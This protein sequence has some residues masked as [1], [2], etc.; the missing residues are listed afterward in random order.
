VPAAAV[1]K[2]EGFCFV[3]ILEFDDRARATGQGGKRAFTACSF[4]IKSRGN[5]FFFFN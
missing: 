1:S 4:R 5:F 3:L 2:I